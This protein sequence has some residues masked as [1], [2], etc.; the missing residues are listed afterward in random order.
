MAKSKQRADGRYQSKIYL[1]CFNGNKKY[2]YVYGKTQKEV[3]DKVLELKISMKKGIDVVSGCDTFE[4]WAEQWLNFK[5]LEISHNSFVTRCCRVDNLQPLFSM[6]ISKIKTIDI[7]MIINH[8]AINPSLTTGKPYAKETLKGIRMVAISIFQLAIENRVIDYN[9]A[10]FVKIPNISEPKIRKAL[11]DEQRNWI[12]DTPHR[13]QCA[14]MIMMFAGLR[15]G[16][17]IP[18]TWFDVDLTKKTII[19]NK[20]VEMINGKPRIKKSAKT[21]AGMRTVHIPQL[22]ADFLSNK[23]KS[24]SLVCTNSNGEMMTGSAWKR[25]WES[26]LLDL[27]L[28]YGDFSK[29]K[30]TNGN[31]PVKFSP[32]KIPFV[33]PH[34]T[35]HCLRHTF[36]TLLYFAGVD[37]LT[38]KEQAGHSDI[39]TTMEIYTHLD[40]DFK[41]KSMSKLDDFLKNNKIENE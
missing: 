30:E 4:I 12:I 39:K 11:T 40:R 27:N 38:A 37:I 9:P 29:C 7:Q 25:M 1:G 22:L 3:D 21:A 13:A 41:Q 6:S 8:Y 23:K 28:K 19:V 35:A 5:K 26:Y 2:K 24:S 18:L 20:S 34:F 32:Q 17:L 33:I 15:R 31:T 36:I 14:A 10:T 16:E